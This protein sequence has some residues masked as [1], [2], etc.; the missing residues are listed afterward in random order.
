MELYPS[1]NLLHTCTYITCTGAAMAS[2]CITDITTWVGDRSS[3]WIHRFKVLL[4]Q[5]EEFTVWNRKW[6]RKNILYYYQSLRTHLRIWFFKV[7]NSMNILDLE[8]IF[9]KKP[10]WFLLIFVFK[11]INYR[12]FRTTIQKKEIFMWGIYFPRWSFCIKSN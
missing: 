7:L 10:N 5:G 12:N 3:R 9:R 6:N 1:F 2:S 4:H 8:K 11:K